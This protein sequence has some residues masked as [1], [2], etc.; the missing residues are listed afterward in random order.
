MMADENEE[1]DEETGVQ[2]TNDGNDEH[3]GNASENGKDS[4]GLDEDVKMQEENEGD[5]KSNNETDNNKEMKELEENSK[6][7][8][9]SEETSQTSEREK[10]RDFEPIYD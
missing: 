7:Q 5:N 9:E 2:M 3:A 4:V 8:L 10:E 6:S 1:E